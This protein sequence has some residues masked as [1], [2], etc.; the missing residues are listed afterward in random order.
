V[1]CL[2]TDPWSFTAKVDLLLSS[3]F[4]LLFSV[5]QLRK[6]LKVEIFNL[7]GENLVTAKCALSLYV[8]GNHWFFEKY[9]SR[10]VILYRIQSGIVIFNFHDYRPLLDMI[11][12]RKSCIRSWTMQSRMTVSFV[13]Q[14]RRASLLTVNASTII[15]R[16]LHD[17][18]CGA[19]IVKWWFNLA[20]SIVMIERKLC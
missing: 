18:S 14:L 9:N 2:K 20:I 17:T 3:L 7:R 5:R 8:K 4:R 19:E 6:A 15:S 11:V 16:D 12:I 10:F 13:C 1:K